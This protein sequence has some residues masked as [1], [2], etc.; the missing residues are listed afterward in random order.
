RRLEVAVVEALDLDQVPAPIPLGGGVS[1]TGHAV[2]HGG[3]GACG[4]CVGSGRGSASYSGCSPG[5]AAPSA[6]GTIPG[7]GVAGASGKELPGSLGAA[8]S[9]PSRVSSATPTGAT[10]AAWP[11]M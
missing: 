6:P 10:A 7:S 9:S 11:A 4:A 2:D 8:V 5:S 3:S 1:E